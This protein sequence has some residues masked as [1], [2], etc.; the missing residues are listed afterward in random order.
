MD[1]KITSLQGYTLMELLVVLAIIGILGAVAVP[2]FSQQIKQSRLTNTAIQLHS[3]YKFA[4]SEAA[5]REKKIDL[6]ATGTG[7]EV[8]MGTEVLSVFKPRHDSVFIVGGLN[9]L[10]L[11]ATGSTSDNSFLISDGSSSTNDYCLYILISG[12]SKLSKQSACS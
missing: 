3:T 4:R 2:A 11:S 5:K 1:K 12:Q 7:W 8:T 6:I 9:D 10:A